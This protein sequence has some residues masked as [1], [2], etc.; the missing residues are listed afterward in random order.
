[1]CNPQTSTQCANSSA[2]QGLCWIVVRPLTSG[3]VT[4]GRCVCACIHVCVCV[5]VRA[6][7]CGRVAFLCWLMDGC[8]T[9]QVVTLR[10]AVSHQSLGT[11]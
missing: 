3:A 4:C 5:S 2:V 1:M 8:A 9:L 6:C 7:V 10:R 11:L